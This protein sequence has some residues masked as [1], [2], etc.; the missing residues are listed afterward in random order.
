MTAYGWLDFAIGSDTG[1][2]VRFPA[3][4]GGLY[5]YKPTHGIF[6]LTG[7]LVAIAE[8]DT[9][10]FMTRSPSI[11]VKV[12]RWWASNTPLAT[13][14]SEFP[15]ELIFWGDEPPLVQPEAEKMKVEFF[16]KVIQALGLPTKS[17]NVSKSWTEYTGIEQN[18]S[19]YMSGVYTTQNSVELW[20]AVGKPLVE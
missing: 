6:N 10:G 9:P 18:T 16:A 19:T 12:G 4:F 3:R 2:S 7:I 11:F 5:G 15:K 20:D 17:V 8:Q 14:P 1:G 13:V